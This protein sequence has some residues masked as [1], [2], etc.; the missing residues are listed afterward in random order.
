[1]E[2]PPPS[3]GPP[4]KV[5]PCVCGT[6]GTPPRQKFVSG[7]DACGVHSGSPGR[8]PGLQS[9]RPWQLRSQPHGLPRPTAPVCHDGPLA[10]HTWW[11]DSPP[12]PCAKPGDRDAP[13]IAGRQTCCPFAL[14]TQGTQTDTWRAHE[15]R[16][17]SATSPRWS[18]SRS[19][20]TQMMP[21]PYL[22]FVGIRL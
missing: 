10:Q 18:P 21:E 1:M 14:T 22:S 13:T 17:H 6:C 3:S 11:Q 5:P 12:W 9:A 20:Q 7:H 2:G 15:P 16:T 4:S 19:S 8:R